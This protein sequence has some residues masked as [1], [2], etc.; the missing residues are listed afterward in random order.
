MPGMRP[1]IMPKKVPNTIVMIISMNIYQ[2]IEIASNMLA[3]KIQKSF[4]E[5]V[6]VYEKNE[7]Y[8]KIGFLYRFK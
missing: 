2:R 8:L 5:I 4:R 7:N 1:V 6:D 3:V